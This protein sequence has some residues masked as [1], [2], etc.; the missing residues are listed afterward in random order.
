[1]SSMPNFTGYHMTQTHIGHGETRCVRCLFGGPGCD[2]WI[3]QQKTLHL[4]FRTFNGPGQGTNVGTG[5]VLV[6]P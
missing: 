3:A 1:M 6:Q 2:A 5:R 4:R